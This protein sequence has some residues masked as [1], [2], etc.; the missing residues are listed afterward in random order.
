MTTRKR[1]S[2]F[3]LP[4]GGL[5]LICATGAFAQ[6]NGAGCGGAGAIGGVGSGALGI[7]A[8][9][10]GAG[11]LGAGGGGAQ[12][13]GGRAFYMTPTLSACATLTNNV[14][15][16]AT[17]KQADLI[18]QVA[19]GLQLGGRSGRIQGF[20]DYTLTALAYARSVDQSNLQNFLNAR[21]SAEAVENWLF[22][23]A[24]A[25]ITQ[26][27]ISPFGSQSPNPSL[28]NPN[29][30]E[31]STLN[32]APYLKGQ[33]AGEVNYLGR[34]FYTYT[35][36]GSSL[37]SNSS[38]FGGILAFD[39]TTRWSKL[40][41]GLNL[42]YREVNFSD[43]TNNSDQLNFA[44]LTYAITPYLNVTARANVETSNLVSADKQT[45][46]GW[47]GGVRWNP[48]PR[49]NLIAE[50]DQRAFGSSHLYSFEYRTPRTVWAISNRQ[51][52]STGQNFGGQGSTG[53]AF[54]LLF[55]QFATV[56]PDPVARTQL[57]NAFIQANGINPNAALSAGYFPSQV[58]L[59]RQQNA[60][61]A[62]L[63]V[64]STLIFN[65]FQTQARA[66]T[67][68]PVLGSDFDN[69]NVLR[70]RGFGVNWAYRLTPLSTVNLNTSQTKTTESIGGQQTNLWTVNAI[71][72]QQLA[73]RIS[74]SLNANYTRF[75]S[76]TA[77]YNETGLQAAM[78]LAF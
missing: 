44:S 23:D 30:T 14:N 31:T 76:S 42:T 70:W 78:N 47:G 11:S 66:L 29:R 38:A 54:D 45:T 63:G 69:G 49:T 74:L 20:L 58:T 65:V 37:A 61:A 13:S 72:T 62:L 32:V 25:S 21:V 19:P 18:A 9:G 34:A 52:L 26:Q 77:P 4:F 2:P 56:E 10:I 5:L 33:I 16:S 28:G 68:N 59:E 64:R 40:S 48:S 17:D 43:G 12:G 46:T 15:L 22:V 75:D 60:S 51:G 53:S 3:G 67:S 27:Y 36:S 41:W 1:F 50:L 24:N 35:N 57:V 7:G 39:A 71:W 6:G 73:A 8:E 55:A